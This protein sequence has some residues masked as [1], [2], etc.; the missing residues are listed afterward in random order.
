MQ[1][2]LDRCGLVQIVEFHVD[3]TPNGAELR[4]RA[5]EGERNRRHQSY[6]DKAK[7]FS[8]LAISSRPLKHWQ[9]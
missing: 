6:Q 5:P 7:P 1:E 8:A 9:F 4:Q 3:V 2:I